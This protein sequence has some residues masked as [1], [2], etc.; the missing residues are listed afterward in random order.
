MDASEIRARAEAWLKADDDPETRAE[1]EELLDDPAALAERFADRLQ[2][3]TAGLRGELGAGP[4]RMNRVIVRQTSA[5]LADYLLEN[6]PRA[7][8]RGVVIG[9]DGRRNSDVFAA[10]AARMF[11]DRGMVVHLSES[12]CATPLAAFAVRDLGAAGGVVITASHN[13][14]A[15]NGYK[16]FWENAAQIVP[17]H[18]AGIAAAI[19][20]AEISDAARELDLDAA[21]KQGRLRRFGEDSERRYRREALALMCHRDAA[22]LAPLTLAYTPLHGVG[23]GPVTRLL[24]EAGFDRLEVEPSQAE[25]D[26]RFPTVEFPNPEEPGATDRLFALADRI[27]ADIAIAN[28]PDADRLSVAVPEGEGYR[29]LSGDQVGA[30]LADYLLAEGDQSGKRLVMTTVVSSQ[31]L[32]AMA[33]A[34]GVEYREVLTGFKWIANGALEAK[35]KRGTRLVIGYEEALGYGIGEVVYDKDGISAALLFAELCAVAKSRGETITSRLERI[36]RELGVFLTKQVSL[37]RPGAEG[38]AEIDGTME[39]F[40]SSPPSAIAGRDVR[41][42]TDLASGEGDLPAADVLIFRLADGSRVI[43]RP[44]GTEPKLKCYY[45]VRE[46]IGEGESVEAATA[47]AESQLEDLIAQHQA[48]LSG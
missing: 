34:R 4:T 2:F 38:R 12:P 7:A 5:G 45:E 22:S 26:G 20:A 13:P 3:G 27:G 32:E 42:F 39:R 44:S 35:A 9:Y 15:Y 6:V 23:A 43:M 29:Q 11:L 41:R 14:P 40:R 33:A 30:L 36:Y 10:C 1:L 47:R 48:S 8:D 16:V 28:D 18:D 25:P 19:E 37:T 31:L 46:D 21:A 24:G 17:P